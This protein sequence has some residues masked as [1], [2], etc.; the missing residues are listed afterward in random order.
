MVS[1]DTGFTPHAFV[2]VTHDDNLFRLSDG[3]DTAATLGSDERADIYRVLAAGID[4]SAQVSR[5]RFNLHG[6][7]NQMRFSRYT[8]LDNEGGAARARWD[9]AVASDWQGGLGYDYSRSL[10]NIGTPE[11]EG[12]GGTER[13]L[14]S[15]QRSYVE[16]DYRFLPRWRLRLGAQDRDLDNSAVS[17]RVLDTRATSGEIA[18]HRL[19]VPADYSEADPNFLGPRWRFTDGD[20]PHPETIGS[21]VIDNGYDQ[22]EVGIVA[23]WRFPGM[24]R[25]LAFV[26]YTERSHDQ[27]A[28][29]D[30]QGTTGRVTF[31]WQVGAKTVLVMSAWRELTVADDQSPSYVVSEGAHLGPDW[32]VT[33]KITLKARLAREERDYRGDPRQFL[34]PTQKRVDD[35]ESLRLALEYEPV[36][37][38]NIAIAWKTGER[39]SN[40]PL[41]DYRYHSISATVRAHF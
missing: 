21:A 38:A 1:A 12:S 6:S 40:L 24:S 20:Y 28:E 5:Q 13:N 9:W 39:E 4:A 18:L 33:P 34:I 32:S 7:V 14:R 30:F 26:G 23:G 16:G 10:A 35:L 2:G 29:R 36:P 41:T 17:R 31:D 37:A 19:S 8:Q 27:V 25:A 22:H 15:E 11:T 3:A